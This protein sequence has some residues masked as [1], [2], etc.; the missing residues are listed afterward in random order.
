MPVLGIVADDLTG[1]M[2]TANEVATRGWETLVVAVRDAAPPDATVVAVNT[3][4]Q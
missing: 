1:A 3:E 2:D 4:S